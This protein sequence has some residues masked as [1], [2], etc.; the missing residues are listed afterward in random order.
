MHRLGVVKEDALHPDA[1]IAWDEAL[2]AWSVRRYDDVVAV[3]GDKRFS[4][5]A[6]IVEPK[7]DRLPSGP[8]PSAARQ[9]VALCVQRRV[10]W[11]RQ[12]ILSAAEASCSS[13][14][15]RRSFDLQQELIVPCCQRLSL[16]LTGVSS[17]G[18]EAQRLFGS[19]QSVFSVTDDG[20]WQNA[21]L[22]TAE[23]SR[24]FLA[25]ITKRRESAQDDLV[26][27]FAQGDDPAHVLLSPVLQLFVG[28]S[29]SLPLLLGNA[30]LALLSDP[31]Q[32]ERTLQQPDQ[33]VGEIL[34]TAGPVQLVYRLTLEN[35]VVGGHA[36]ER[37]DRLALLFSEANQDATPEAHL[38]FG[39]GVHSCLGA[40]IIQAAVE[41]L[42]HTILNRF[43]G[44]KPDASGI[45]RGGSKTIRGVTALPV[46]LD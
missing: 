23:L 2:A 5:A 28:V 24:Y 19:A 31:E 46:R 7:P 1:P 38:T 36:F 40:P 44:L 39:K 37:G 26:S 30:L 17:E 20:Q 29:T 18:A 22:A 42:P 14:G 6:G 35:A 34:R 32:A 13:L 25:L 11:A 27:A 21:E 10:Q 43:P 8:D 4:A 45:R 33:A 16:L 15:T 12:Q 3:L 9:H 41:I